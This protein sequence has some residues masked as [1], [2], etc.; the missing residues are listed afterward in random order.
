MTI[1]FKHEEV[2]Q[3][4]AEAF[5]QRETSLSRTLGMMFSNADQI[6]SQLAGADVS[7]DSLFATV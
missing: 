3:D 1:R 7:L 2:I 5:V 6:A 4:M